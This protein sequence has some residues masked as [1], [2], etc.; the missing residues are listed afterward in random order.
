MDVARWLDRPHP[1][2]RQWTRG[3]AMGGAPQDNE[4]AMRLLTK[5]E[6]L[7]QYRKGFPVPRLKPR[8]RKLYLAK[9]RKRVG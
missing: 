9:L 8:D 4:E 1:T 5:L 3:T 7:I 6:F 2:V